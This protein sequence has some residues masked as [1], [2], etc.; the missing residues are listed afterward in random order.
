ML[1]QIKKIG[2]AAVF[3]AGWSLTASAWTNGAVWRDTA[4]YAVNAHGGGVLAHEG[5]YYLYG[6]HK[7]YGARG[8]RAHGGVHMYSSRDL[9]TWT[10][11]G[12]VLQ[13][14]DQPG[15]DIEDGCILERPKILFCD[16]TGKFVLFFHLELKG[17]G[18]NT[19]R[20]GIAVAD[21]PTGPYNYLR[22]LRPNAGQWPVEI[23]A[24]DRTDAT[25]DKFRTI[26]APWD[27]AI[28]INLWGEHFAGGQMCRDQTLFK[29]DDGTAYH[30]FASEDNSTLHIA[31]LTDDYLDYTGR[32][33]RAAVLDWTEA[34]AI[35]KKDGWYYLIGSGCTGWR[36]NAAR[37][38]RARSMMGPWERFGNPVRGVNPANGMGPEKTWGAQSN[39]LLKTFAGEWIAM[40]DIWRPQNQLDSR[41]VW[42][43]VDFHADHTIS[44][45]WRDI[46]AEKDPS[47]WVDP[48]IGASANG[49]TTAA[50]A[51]PFGL[52][53]PGPDTGNCHWHY[54]SGYRDAD[55]ALYG[56]SQTHLSG[57]GSADLGDLLI[58]PVAGD[59]PEG[60]TAVP[61]L[62]ETEVAEPGYYAVTLAD[63]TRC[64]TSVTPR[65]AIYR[66]TFAKE[67][68][69]R[70]LVDTQWGIVDRP[71][72]FT[73]HRLAAQIDTSDPN[74][75]SGSLDETG[76]VDRTWHFALT[77]D[78]PRTQ[79][80]ELPRLAGEKAPRYLLDFDLGAERTLVV[81]LSLS[82]TDV[83]GA[84][85]NL[86]AE[87]AGKTLEDV[88]GAART[89]WNKYLSRMEVVGTDDDGKRGFYTS[90]Y[91]LFFQPNNLSDVGEKPFYTTFS[92]WD[93][94][95]AAHPLYTILA[96]ERVPG[97]ID[98]L[99]EQGRR[100]GYL[101]IWTLWGIENQGMIGTHSVPV[102]VDWFLKSGAP[103]T[104]YWQAAFEQIKETL[105]QPHKGRRKERWD[106]Y[107]T[108]G[109]YPFDVITGESVSRTLECAY[110]DACAARMAE[111]LG[112]AEDAAFFAKRAGYWKN[113]F[114]P[115][116][117][118]MR[119]RDT[120]GAWRTP[121]DP[122]AVGHNTDTANDFTEG[123]AYHY[124]WHVL[125]DPEAF[126]AAFGGK[127]AF[128][129]ELNSIFSLSDRVEG[130]G[131][132]VDVTGL[133]GQYAHGNE[134]SHHVIYYFQY[135]DRG[136]RTAELV[137]EVFDRFYLPKPD[138]LCGN[139]DCGQMSAW[140]LFS[141][142]GFY[143]FDPCGGDYVLGAPQFP[144]IRLNLPQGK[145]F[146]IKAKGLSKDAKFVKSVTLNGKSLDGFI[147][148]HAEIMAGGEL[149][150]DMTAK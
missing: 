8:N 23:A 135:A 87:V 134:P 85:R 3:V 88:R 129:K 59:A 84:M 53:Q 145:T 15:S 38:Y 12:L 77:T 45:T 98:S 34:P 148:K 144:E 26:A 10:D 48:R 100:T 114:D 52:L 41:L 9:E 108:Y 137:R 126:V 63:G 57:T 68:P 140:Y 90:L 47:R 118:L 29:D 121:Y 17:Q 139:D 21:K 112:R 71:E 28:T 138:G 102:I 35:C 31:E 1:D 18:Y 120:K 104:A 50:A 36:P 49:H 131:T 122:A 27:D 101:P 42:L 99:L 141:A 19:A 115:S 123:N 33:T 116:L 92:L 70:L 75:L 80:V 20:V 95:R 74:G 83:A 110:D 72:E 6:E 146:T 107:D 2:V 37:A 106:L 14:E 13:V 111:A 7:I 39:Y 82:A 58:L 86:R 149:V 117:K 62:K 24:A 81:R 130:P 69:H 54:C 67:G 128:Y 97:M 109:Y 105:T 40:F 76:W 16:K 147:L 132:T 96:P 22:S 143:P 43:P 4:G 32:W 119:G 133:I 11:E 56:F 125:H 66:F 142:M 79:L 136:D 61:F 55:R 94:F 25:L 44:V 5:V 73:I 60:R 78:H 30:V 127:A 91:H 124:T 46:A 65:G 64:E 93:T 113:V 51:Y 103:K 89:E 150:F